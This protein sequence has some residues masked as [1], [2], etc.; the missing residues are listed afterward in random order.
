QVVCADVLQNL[1]WYG[2][3]IPARKLTG[4]PASLALA[5]PLAY[6]GG[7][8]RIR[9]VT[10]RLDARC[11]LRGELERFQ[12]MKV[13][14]GP[15]DD[16]PS[17]LLDQCFRI[18]P[19]SYAE[20]RVRSNDD[21]DLCARR[22]LAAQATECVDGVVGRA[23]LRTVERA[24][25]CGC[26]DAV[27]S[28]AEQLDHVQAVG[29]GGM[30]AARFEWLNGCG[31]E[32]HA[33]EREAVADRLG[34]GEM[35]SMRRIEAAAEEADSHVAIVPCVLPVSPS[36]LWPRWLAG[37]VCVWLPRRDDGGV[38]CGNLQGW[39][40]RCRAAH[41]EGARAS[42]RTDGRRRA[43]CGRRWRGRGDRARRH[44][45]PADLRGVW[46]WPRPVVRAWLRTG[47]GRAWRLCV[48]RAGV[49]RLARGSGAGVR[50]A[51]RWQ[52]A[53]RRR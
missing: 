11:L 45:R 21:K 7:A 27:G 9:K 15:A 12:L 46:P 38:C 53:D 4:E 28:I 25:D 33:V 31:C 37:V 18:L 16:D 20:K 43:V 30:G 52:R 1:R 23:G 51:A 26:L 3:V 35:A 49:P 36:R 34:Y 5:Q 22:Q 19:L 13:E 48:S 24:V 44:R 17:C 42:A 14:A 47:S 39:R 29:E 2:I 10:Q 8:D 41:R 50:S 40:G 6:F 32:Q